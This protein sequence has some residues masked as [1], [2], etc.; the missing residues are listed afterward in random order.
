M[1]SVSLD[2]AKQR[3]AELLDR[4]EAGEAVEITRNGKTVA[5]LLPADRVTNRID[6]ASLKAVTDMQS[7]PAELEHEFMRKLRDGD[8]Y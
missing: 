6:A 4:V 2:D 8:R 1:E 7:A 3:L 5:R